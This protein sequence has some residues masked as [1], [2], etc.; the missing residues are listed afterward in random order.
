[1]NFIHNYAVKYDIYLITCIYCVYTQR[2]RENS[3]F[4]RLNSKHWDWTST[5][6]MAR[7]D[8]LAVGRAKSCSNLVVRRGY[9]VKHVGICENQGVWE[10]YSTQVWLVLSDSVFWGKP[11]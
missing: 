1:M 10:V 11:T 2:D 6:H 8:C 7:F 9:V 5:F 3:R 4:A